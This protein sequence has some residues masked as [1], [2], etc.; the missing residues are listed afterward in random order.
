MGS[1]PQPFGAQIPQWGVTEPTRKAWPSGDHMGPP[2]PWLLCQDGLT[3]APRSPQP[4]HRG[5]HKAQPDQPARS[6]P[7]PETQAPTCALNSKW[8]ENHWPHSNHNPEVQQSPEP[9]GT[10]TAPIRD[11]NVTIPEAARRDTQS[12]HGEGPAGWGHQPC[13][14]PHLYLIRVRPPDTAPTYT[15]LPSSHRHQRVSWELQPHHGK[16]QALRTRVTQPH[17]TGL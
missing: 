11:A 5:P 16:A 17:T 6:L 12:E 7:N 8:R 2:P 9:S 13:L 4:G 15:S 1:V 14:H 3:Q 10:P